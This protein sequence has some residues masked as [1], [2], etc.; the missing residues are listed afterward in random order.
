M[1]MHNRKFCHE[2]IT[3]NTRFLPDLIVTVSSSSPLTLIFIG[4]HLY[5]CP[6][7]ASSL[8]QK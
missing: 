4:V 7:Q 6:P 1:E 5:A 3:V 8:R 2:N